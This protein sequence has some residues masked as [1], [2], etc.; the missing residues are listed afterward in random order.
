MKKYFCGKCKRKYNFFDNIRQVFFK[1]HYNL[2]NIAGNIYTPVCSKCYKILKK[3]QE[4][5]QLLHKHKVESASIRVEQG[6]G[7]YC[8]CKNKEEDVILLLYK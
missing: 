2:V 3:E 1:G 6:K 8:L 5:E 7:D 4:E